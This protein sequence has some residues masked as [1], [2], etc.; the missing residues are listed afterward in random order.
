M[1]GVTFQRTMDLA[2]PARATRPTTAAP[3]AVAS[4]GDDIP[5]GVNRRRERAANSLAAL[6]SIRAERP[7]GAP[8]WARRCADNAG[9]SPIT[10]QSRQWQAEPWQALR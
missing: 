2:K 10:A 9:G 8:V 5:W 3:T 1:L 4:I 6:P 7:D